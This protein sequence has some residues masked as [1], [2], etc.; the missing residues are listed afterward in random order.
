MYLTDIYIYPI[1]SLGG[2]RLNE[3]VLEERGL[4]YDRRWMLV[5]KNGIFLTQR[6]LHQMALIQVE[7]MAGGLN[8][9]RKD[10][11]E[12]NILIPFE[13]KTKKLIPVAVWDDTVIGQLVDNSVSKWFTNQL[14]I[15][16]DLVVMPES[17]QR[18]LNPKYAVNNESVSFADGMP[19]LLIGQA[20]LD[21]L[22]TKLQNPVPMDRFRPNLV[23]SGGKAFEED[24][25]DKVKIGKSLFKITKP[26]AR[27]V[28]TTIDQK[29]GI[30][31]K[32]PL[33]T[34][35]K[36]RT[37]SNKVMFGQNMSL[38]EGLTIRLGD[39]VSPQ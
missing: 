23:F 12:T 2:I 9:F 29:T 33:K 7:L 14:N 27:C 11:P 28:M 22:N 21:D 13:P 37:V 26:C 32:E 17:T 18:K 10:D 38:L 36:Y 6:T 25:W 3:S 24:E 35:A 19:Y 31:G 20:S 16:C 1:K 5:D 39:T 15:D 30:K 4:K 8:V 34:L